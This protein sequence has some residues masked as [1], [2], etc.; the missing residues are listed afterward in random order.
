MTPGPLWDL[1]ARAGHLPAQARPSHGLPPVPDDLR[2][3]RG[4]PDALEYPRRSAPFT[5][6][7]T[8]DHDGAKRAFTISEMRNLPS[9]R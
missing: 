8:A 6:S 5:M 7:E 2:T 3:P 4:M 9:R 1:L